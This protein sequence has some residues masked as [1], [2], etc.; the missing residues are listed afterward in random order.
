MKSSFGAWRPLFQLP[1]HIPRQLI[2]TN[3]F[4]SGT[5]CTRKN[6][7]N[8]PRRNDFFSARAGIF[9][10]LD[11]LGFSDLELELNFCLW[12]ETSFVNMI[13]VRLFSLSLGLFIPMFTYAW[14]YVFRLPSLFIQRVSNNTIYITDQVGSGPCLDLDMVSLLCPIISIYFHMSAHS[15][16]CILHRWSWSIR[17]NTIQIPIQVET[18][19][20]IERI[21]WHDSLLSPRALIMILYRL[22]FTFFSLL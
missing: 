21:Q 3:C 16:Y 8:T 13:S 17:F 15:L 20:Q 6:S 12:V 1:E 14:V 2:C 11:W 10:M 7:I 4:W 18:L 9:F 19:L 5:K 22:N